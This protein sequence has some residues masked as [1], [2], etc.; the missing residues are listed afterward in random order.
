MA[1]LPDAAS[2]E[3]DSFVVQDER[4]FAARDSR[5][6]FTT[7][8]N[9]TAALPVVSISAARGL[10]PAFRSASGIPDVDTVDLVG[11]GLAQ[12]T[13]TAWTREPHFEARRS[14]LVPFI[15][16]AVHAGLSG[17]G[18]V[19]A[20]SVR[21]SDIA[22]FLDVVDTRVDVVRAESHYILELGGSRSMEEF[23][24]QCSNKQGKTWEGD[25]Q[26]SAAAGLSFDVE[27]L[28]SE[29]AAEM[30]PALAA[31]SERNGMPEMVE[32]AE[33]RML[34]ILSRPGEHLCI[35]IRMEG[36]VIGFGGW[37]VAGVNV[38]A[39]TFAFDGD[40]GLQRDVYLYLYEACLRFALERGSHVIHLGT[41]HGHPKRAR[42]CVEQGRW[43]VTYS[44]DDKVQSDR[45]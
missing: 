5:L 31:T 42:G 16:A 32:L 43:H 44:S 40:P 9:R 14:S 38:L 25:I 36:E 2:Q 30:A 1:L 13:T 29:I 3:F 8:G 26:R 22:S 11:A 24:E 17:S 37:T 41:G 23:F 12:L 33:W 28:T 45:R 21:A 7:Y 6:A 19:I 27:P 35:R 18:T 4:A 10:S 20:S 34:G 15:R 39:H